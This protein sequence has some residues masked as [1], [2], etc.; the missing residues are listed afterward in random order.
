MRGLGEIRADDPRRAED[1]SGRGRDGDPDA[2][3]ERAKARRRVLVRPDEEDHR[4]AAGQVAIGSRRVVV[5]IAAIG[6]AVSASLTGVPY[7]GALALCIGVGGGETV[8]TS[9]WSM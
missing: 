7:P 9:R 1:R 5:A 3:R 4:P 8:Q 6:T 2:L